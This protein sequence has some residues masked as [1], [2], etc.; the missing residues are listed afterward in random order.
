MPTT[1]GL[2]Y[3]LTKKKISEAL[4]IYERAIN[5]N[6]KNP[7]TFRNRALIYKR[8]GKFELAID[9]F[10]TAIKL[11][12]KDVDV[13]FQLGI[14]YEAVRNFADAVKAYDLALKLQP[15]HEWALNNRCYSKAMLEDMSAIMDCNAALRL[16]EDR[17]FYDGRGFA[18]LKLGQFERA[19][20]DYDKALSLYPAGSKLPDQAYSLYGRGAAKRM[21]GDIGAGNADIAAAKR[22]KR[23]VEDEMSKLNVI[24]PDE[25]AGRKSLPSCPGRNGES[26][27]VESCF[28]WMIGF[29][30]RA[31][32]CQKTG[33]VLL[34]AGIVARSPF[35]MVHRLLL[36]DQDQ[37]VVRHSFLFR[38]ARVLA[39]SCLARVTSRP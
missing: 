21:K 24:T 5:A 39:R 27:H 22:L 6:P 31:P 33:N 23:G 11:G 29:L 16:R 1:D 34:G 38:T 28:T 36:I 4:A 20:D 19:I 17:A 9:D 7:E 35:G 15:R 8:D 3:L 26:G 10:K 32:R 12:L 18:H 30:A 37:D 13:F 2:P 25:V 14:T